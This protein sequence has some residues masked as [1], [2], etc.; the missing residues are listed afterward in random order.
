VPQ[1][2]TPATWLER[3]ER[4]MDE[5]WFHKM[6][7]CDAYFEG[8]QKLA[9]A[10]SQFREAFGSLFSAIADNWMPLVVES[11]TERMEVQG[12]RFG[13]RESADE[14]AWDIWQESGL[15][16]EADKAHTEAVKLG[17]AYW[18]VEPPVGDDAPRITFETPAEVI[19]ALSPGDRR[20]RLAALKKWTD[21]DGFV[22]ATLYLPQWIYKYRSAE[23][24]KAGKRI[25]WVRRPDDDGGANPLGVVPIIPLVNAPDRYGRGVSDLKVAMPIQDGINKLLSDMLLTSEFMAFPQRVLLGIE[26][27]KDPATGQ[28]I[29]AAQLQSARSRLWAFEG[30]AESGHAPDV[31]EF[32]SADLTNYVNA[33]QHLIRGFTAKTRCPPHYVLGEIVNASGDALTAAEAGLTSKTRKKFRPLGEG[34]EEALRLGFLSMGDTDRARDTAGAET[35]WKDPERLSLAQ[36]ADAAVKKKDAGVPWEQRMIDLGYSPPEIARMQAQRI[37]DQVFEPLELAGAPSS[38][39]S[40]NGASV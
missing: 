31:K 6:G 33:R 29:S 12:F 17:E 11:T 38:N 30:T 21:E 40:A 23:K 35:I 28:P 39:G 3:L 36:L 13:K 16:A 34:H 37:A 1:Q 19:V 24:A 27:P 10:T 25:Q 8:D 14:T 22:Y 9:F 26:I 5:R 4:R 20:T 2:L 32:S 18:L 15:D 7:P